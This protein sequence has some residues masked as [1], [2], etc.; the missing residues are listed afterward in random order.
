MSEQFVLTQHRNMRLDVRDMGAI[1]LYKNVNI[2]QIPLNLT[3]QFCL[4]MMK[5][6]GDDSGVAII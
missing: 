5:C 1:S 4:A 3:V 2:L 6:Q